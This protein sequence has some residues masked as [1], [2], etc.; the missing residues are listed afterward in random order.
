VKKV[1][2]KTLLSTLKTAHILKVL[3]KQSVV[4]KGINKRF[5]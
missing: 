4:N 2:E 1:I 5:A 3:K